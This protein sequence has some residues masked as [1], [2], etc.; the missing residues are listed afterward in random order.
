MA[1]PSP[2]PTVYQYGKHK[3]EK[4]PAIKIKQEAER[5]LKVKKFALPKR[6]PGTITE[7]VLINEASN[8]LD[9]YINTPTAVTWSQFFFKEDTNFTICYSTFHQNYKKYESV[10]EIMDMLKKVQENRLI[11]F[12]HNGTYKSP[13]FSMFLLKNKHGYVDKTEQKVTVTDDN[14]AFN[15]GNF[16]VTDIDKNDLDDANKKENI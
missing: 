8:L 5:R 11:E 9:W 14:I 6:K 16:E 4:K 15:F 2:D 1:K 12:T 7:E 10:N 13:H 3:G